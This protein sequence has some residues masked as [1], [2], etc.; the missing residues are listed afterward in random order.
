V[1]LDHTSGLVIRAIA[2]ST[3]ERAHVAGFANQTRLSSQ[4]VQV[5]VA[6]ILPTTGLS[7]GSHYYL[8][9]TTFGLITTTPPSGASK[10][11]TYVGEAVTATKLSIQL[12]PPIQLS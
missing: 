2:N 3:E 1:C 5:L 9:D 4:T 8:S 7:P 10:Y 6:G 12:T 11:V